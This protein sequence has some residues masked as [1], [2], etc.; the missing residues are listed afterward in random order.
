[1]PSSPSLLSAIAL[2]AAAGV[3]LDRESTVI[4]DPVLWGVEEGLMPCVF[5]PSARAQ[6]VAIAAIPLPP[7]PAIVPRVQVPAS[8][9]P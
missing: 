2:L 3:W 7:R 8:R 4:T 6:A 5:G 9:Q 1:M